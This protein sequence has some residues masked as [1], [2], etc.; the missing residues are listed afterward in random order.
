MRVSDPPV[1]PIHALANVAAP[2]VGERVRDSGEVLALVDDETV[3]V[4]TADE[5]GELVH[6]AGPWRKAPQCARFTTRTAAPPEADV[7]YQPD[8]VAAEEA[9]CRRTATSAVFFPT[10]SGS[11]RSSSVANA[12]REVDLLWPKP[13][14][15]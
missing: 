6:R 8:A 7:S 13:R 5:E 2:P 3:T 10:S 11:V 1:L 9:V 14:S 12:A 15:A 4:G